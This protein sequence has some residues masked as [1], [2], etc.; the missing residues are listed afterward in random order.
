L[1]DPTGNCSISSGFPGISL[2]WV[3]FVCPG[4]DAGDAAA[5]AGR[6]A[7]DFVTS[8]VNLLLDASYLYAQAT[9]LGAYESDPIGRLPVL[10]PVDGY[11]G[12]YLAGNLL[13]GVGTTKALLSGTR[14][15]TGYLTRIGARSVAT[16]AAGLLD[17]AA[18]AQLTY[19]E[20]F[21]AGGRFAGQTIDDVAAGLSSGALSPRNVPIHVI[22]RD[23]NSLI[24]STRSAQ[25]LTR[26]GVSRSDWLT[27]NMTGNAAAEARLTAQLARNSL[28]NAGFFYPR[29]TG[30]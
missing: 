2:S 27:V 28:D 12:Q 22:V 4:Q 21:S 29:S 14:L 1:I 7:F 5:S 16:N 26:A 9:S 19:R 6:G 25:A 15:A 24:L 13:A 23:G 8:T 30:K 3:S 20:S 10:G 17:D 11:G 18:F